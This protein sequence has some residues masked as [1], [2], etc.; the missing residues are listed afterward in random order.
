MPGRL[1]RLPPTPAG[2][3]QVLPAPPVP[4]RLRR[5]A[6][7]PPGGAGTRL[8]APRRVVVVGA[9]MAGL[10]AAAACAGSGRSVTLLDKDD[11]AQTGE[12][13]EPLP[14]AGVPQGRQPH[15]FLH[16]GLLEAEK[17][18]PGLRDDLVRRGGVPF[19]TARL[20]WHS[21]Q[22]WMSADGRAYEVVSATRPLLE[23][24]VRARVVALPGVELRWGVR[25]DGLERPTGADA[26]PA[27]GT[28]GVRAGSETFAA[29]LVVDA[30]GRSSRLGVWLHEIGIA[31]AVVEEI[32][33]RVGYATR[34]YSGGPEVLN[35][36]GVILLASPDDPVG[37]GALLME[38][39][40]WLVTAVGFGDRRPPRDV[41]G[42]E[43]FLR[44][45]PDPALAD[46]AARCTP[47]SDVS[48]HRQT[49]NRRHRYERVP[50]WPDGLLTIGDALC[51]F[52]PIYAQGITV[53]ACE[54]AL[55]REVLDATGAGGGPRPG[56][57]EALLRRFASAADL[58]WAV[59]TGEDLRFLPAGAPRGPVERAFG[60]YVRHVDR[61]A[62][63][64]DRDAQLQLSRLYHLMGSPAELFR[65][66]LVVSALRAALFGYGPAVPRPA[67]LDALHSAVTA[68]L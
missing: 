45:L 59:A 52:N 13:G 30:S 57:C 2:L 36:P 64:R 33:A 51:T 24:V 41:Q 58:P 19:D 38:D 7:V 14:R 65:P 3:K 61:M 9:S 42:F 28:W 54:A 46:V 25:V 49:A 10:L 67:S 1:R 56:Y 18:L 17:L 47:I 68:D 23:D 20:A 48:T 5:M 32:D 11:P 27:P 40:R 66:A 15:V 43:T 16:R 62:T 50:S 31:P 39:R 4:A 35:A 22:G 55:L 6:P 12:N 34:V 44:A 37:G 21:D 8:P 26:A 29:D 60:A 53:A 63:H